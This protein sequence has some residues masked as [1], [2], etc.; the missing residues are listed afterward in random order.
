MP[1]KFSAISDTVIS[2]INPDTFGCGAVELQPSLSL[3]ELWFG[4][5]ERFDEN[6]PV[7][8]APYGDTMWTAPVLQLTRQILAGNIT[9]D[10]LRHPA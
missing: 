9:H 3:V 5:E 1:A 4:R 2:A 10:E 8:S 7:C 6:R